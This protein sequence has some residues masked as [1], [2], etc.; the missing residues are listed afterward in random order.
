M[1]SQSKTELYAAIRR[2]MRGGMSIRAVMRKHSVSYLTV[3]KASASAWP[4][5]RKNR[6]RGRHGWH[7]PAQKPSR[8]ARDNNDGEAL[9]V[10]PEGPLVGDVGG[11]VCLSILHRSEAGRPGRVRAWHDA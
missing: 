6:P 2:D 3:T 1:L 10:A 7:G 8:P 11:R 9:D 4:E 5:L